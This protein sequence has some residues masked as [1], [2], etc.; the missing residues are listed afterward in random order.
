MSRYLL[1]GLLLAAGWPA[2]ARSQIR[3]DTLEIAGEISK[4]ERQW[5]DALVQQ[6]TAVLQRLLAPEYALIVSASPERPIVRSAWLST[7][8]DYHTRSL[9]IS[10]LTVR[11]FGDVALASFVADLVA[12][13]R[14]A[15]RR[16]K[17]FLTDVWKLR[18]G[19][20]QVIARYSAR[21]EEAS[22]STR[23]LE[24]MAKD[25]GQSR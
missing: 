23:V 24:Q 9:A 10:G 1:L 6:D 8:R 22:A 4:L 20:W 14:G 18:A 2:A 5:A 17:Y 3:Y 12:R 16:G 25:S 19:R 11:V 13:V 15:E 7:L 21:P